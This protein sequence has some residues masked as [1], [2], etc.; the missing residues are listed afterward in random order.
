MI[1]K[2]V[3]ILFLFIGIG[4]AVIFYTNW[5]I[6]HYSKSK[7]FSQISSLKHQKVGLLLGTSKYQVGGKINPYFRNRVEA[8]VKLFEHGKID[9]ILVSGDNAHLNYNEPRDLKRSLIERGIPKDKIIL[10]YAGFRTLDSVIRA[11]L[12]FGQDSIIIISQKFH[13]ERAI[14]IAE[15]NGLQAEGFNA[16]DPHSSTR[17]SLREYLAKTVAYFD[18]LINRQPKFLGEPIKIE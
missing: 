11:H 17:V 6:H 7:T 12:V 1:K 2:F 10:D 9:Y 15:K 14:Y 4:V 18:V 5:V 16:K 13:T 3:K 8:S